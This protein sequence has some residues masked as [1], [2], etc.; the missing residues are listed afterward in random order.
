MK[1]Y[2]KYLWIAAFCG[3]FCILGCTRNFSEILL[4]EILLIP[5]FLDI[6][7]CMQ[8]IPNITF[9]Y[10][11]LLLFQVFYGT[12]IYRRF[13]CASIYY[14]SRCCNRVGWFLKECLRMYIFCVGYL[15]VF[16]VSGVIATDIFVKVTVDAVSIY[17]FVY[18]VLIYSFFLL[19]TTV[20]VNLF[21]IL[22]TSN[23]GFAVVESFLFL[24]IA[25][26]TMSGEYFI[27]ENAQVRDYQW[28]VKSNLFSHL[29]FGIHSS[30]V[31]ELNQLIHQKEI[32]FDLDE[33]LLLFIM[34]SVVTI[35]AGCIIVHYHD[36]INTNK[37]KGGI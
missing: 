24:C 37:E 27:P 10:V 34:L 1:H 33:S 9:G 30:K 17:I 36:F 28:L 4:S 32:L 14:F 2:M 18:Y 21:G 25:I 11:P 8:Y 20:A 3:F 13:C 16:V 12:Y 23:V 22:F 15:V 29:V 19:F 5:T 31:E 26:Y 6:D 35:I 7:Y